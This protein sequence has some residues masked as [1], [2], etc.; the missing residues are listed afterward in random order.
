MYAIDSDHDDIVRWFIDRFGFN[1]C[2]DGM[3]KES[4]NL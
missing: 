1:L 2:V 4:S 3:D